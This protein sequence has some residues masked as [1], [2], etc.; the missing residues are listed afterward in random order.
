MPTSVAR[1]RPV[2]QGEAFF[3]LAASSRCGAYAAIC[4]SSA[5]SA[6]MRRLRAQYAWAASYSRQAASGMLSRSPFSC[7]SG[8]TDGGVGQIFGGIAVR[9]KLLLE[10]RNESDFPARASNRLG[11]EGIFKVGIDP[12]QEIT[13]ATA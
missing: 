4:L 11:A 6:Y 12:A 3:L 10:R 7:R 13:D 9:W 5:G 1:R 8:A 2:F